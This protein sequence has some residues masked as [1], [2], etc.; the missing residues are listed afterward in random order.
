MKPR[1]LAR[2]RCSLQVDSLET[3]RLLSTG[4]PQIQM[5]SPTQPTDTGSQV[6]YIAAVSHGYELPPLFGGGVPAWETTMVNSLRASGNFKWVDAFDWK[7]WTGQPNYAT[8]A[9]LKLANDIGKAVQNKKIVPPGSVVDIVLIGH[10]RGAV[11][12]NRAFQALQNHLNKIPQLMGGTWQEVLLDP[13][14]SNA[15]TDGLRSYTGFEGTT[16]NAAYLSLQGKMKD[17]YPIKVPSKVSEV[18][19]YWENTPVSDLTTQS[20]KDNHEDSFNVWG[21]PPGPG[22]VLTNRNTVLKEI[23]LTGPGMGHSEVPVWYQ[24]NVVPTLK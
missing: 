17:P 16:I 19:D 21:V 14:P 13:H 7:S 9:G 22:L 3:R 10:S 11:V 2:R 23:P 5:V 20:N 4:A 18:D 15:A 8:N 6:V 1:N 12:V 24:T